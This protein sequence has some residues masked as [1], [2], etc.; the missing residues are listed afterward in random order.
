MAGV[1]YSDI[2]ATGSTAADGASAKAYSMLYLKGLYARP[3]AWKHLVNVSSDA[4]FGQT[5]SLDEMPSIAAV[6]VT[7]A[8]GAYAYENTSLLQRVITMDKIKAVPYSVP[9]YTLVQSKIDLRA[10][11]VENAAKS[12]DD[13]IDAEMAKLCVSL[14]TNSAGSL[15]SDLTETYIFT[16][17]QK[18]VDN[19]VDISNTNDL[20][21]I[22][23][24]SQFAVVHLL[25]GYTSYRTW[26]G[27]SDADGGNDIKP[28]VLSLCGIDVH[29]R[30]DSALSITGGKVGGLFHKD[31]VGVAIQRMP[32]L[33]Q[34]FPIA[35]T[36]N[37][38]M[39]TFAIY[40]IN[41]LAEKRGCLI[42]TK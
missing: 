20:V 2:P 4:G 28:N 29:F 36:V 7:V 24:S 13:S 11:L 8:T 38:D 41:I 39:T 9:E 12:V 34:P 5:V 14:T 27:S 1:M 31:S 15:G 25:K 35:G 42:N 18:L 26:A 40:G 33:R 17:L 30:T 6:D 21:W 10:A 32:S 19:K 22:L 37:W 3:G 16:A 23:P